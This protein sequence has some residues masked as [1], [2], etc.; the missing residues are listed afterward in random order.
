[1][2]NIIYNF[3]T[4]AAG[5]DLP[6]FIK[7]PAANTC[8][9]NNG[10]HILDVLKL[11][12]KKWFHHD[13]EYHILNYE[14]SKITPD[15]VRTSGLFRSVVI[16]N[17]NILAFSPPKSICE[18]QFMSQYPPSECYAEEIIDG[19]MINLF[20]DNTINMWE[21]SS[22]SNFGANC[23]F[24]K[25]GE[26]IE[27]ESFSYMFFEICKTIGFDYTSLPKE[28]CYSF[29]FQHPKNRMVVPIKEMKLYLIASYRI[30][31]EN[32]TI[33][34]LENEQ[35]NTF[36]KGTAIQRPKNY[37]FT[38]YDDLETLITVMNEDYKDAGIMIYHGPSGL[39][40]KIRNPNYEFVKGLR[41]NQPKLQYRYLELRQKGQVAA[42][43]R[44]YPEALSEFNK[45]KQQIHSFT[46]E[47]HTHYINC[48][49]KKT[50]PLLE[51]AEKF[52][53]HMFNIHQIYKKKAEGSGKIIT[54]TDVITYVNTLPEAVL[55]ASLNSE[56]NKR[57]IRVEE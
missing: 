53:T 3:S 37:N 46:E 33:T 19:T 17:G 23:L 25:S 16:S 2:T 42:Y 39:R 14:K 26:F 11:T 21:I 49:I 10:K 56:F 41:G 22:K 38:T 35:L 48:Y 20:Y 13:Q 5:Y 44:Y 55:M 1:M 15:L 8:A 34:K 18:G 51:F 45:Y 6:A 32:Y 30:N 31:N 12:H 36:L 27:K 40:T 29:V 52:R 57:N 24:F 50:C 43:L 4:K 9:S 47:L 54:K 7:N 28:N